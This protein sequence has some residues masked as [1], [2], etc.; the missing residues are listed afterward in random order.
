MKVAIVGK[1]GTSGL[2]PWRDK[3]WEIWG[4]PW[5]SCPRVTRLFDVHTQ[6]FWDQNK[7]MPE[8]SW[9]PACR[10]LYPDIPVYCD[11]S[12]VHAFNKA[13]AYP[14]EAIASLPFAY[15]ENTIAYELALAIHEGVGEI[16]LWGIHMMGSHEFAAERPSVTYL[17]GLAQGKGI[18]VSIAPGSPLMMSCHTAGRY[19][20][21]GGRRI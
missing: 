9:M 4:M 15:L 19:G 18:K 7:D 2:A 3:E 11:P 20:H 10:E 1:A 6:E 13:V 14:S 17:I 21:T 5:I 8:E 16:A 12:R